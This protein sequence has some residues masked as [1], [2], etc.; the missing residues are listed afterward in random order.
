M[1]KNFSIIKNYGLEFCRRGIRTCVFISHSGVHC[2]NPHCACGPAAML[3]AQQR[4]NH[5]IVVLSR[6]DA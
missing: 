3:T 6:C 1:A 2:S 5:H 4:S